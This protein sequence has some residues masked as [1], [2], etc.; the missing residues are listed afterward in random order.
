[1]PV[2]E[3]PEDAVCCSCFRRSAS[4][5]Q[6]YVNA[7]LK[8]PSVS[9]VVPFGDL[10]GTR[11]WKSR[12]P[13]FGAPTSLGSTTPNGAIGLTCLG[14]P[15]EPRNVALMRI[16]T[17]PREL[18]A[19]IIRRMECEESAW[20]PFDRSRTVS[21]WRVMPDPHQ[22]RACMWRV[23]TILHGITPNEVCSMLLDTERW[24]NWR[25]DVTA[26]RN[27][28]RHQGCDVT[29]TCYQGAFL[30]APRETLELSAALCEKELGEL[31]LGWTSCG[32]EDVDNTAAPGH[33]RSFV[34]LAG[35]RL[36]SSPGGTDFT[37]LRQ[38]DLGGRVPAWRA[39]RLGRK[40]CLRL[41]QDLQQAAN[42]S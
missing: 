39:A 10:G 6:T 35:C 31:W 37:F 25:T 28:G 16:P 34:L 15:D 30:L 32:A 11:S 18:L 27:H 36:R 23:Q 40:S 41:C 22:K 26:A 42:R 7:P 13:S 3:L 38:V 19:T 29:S 2:E 9:N 5:P 17:R 14:E 20:T 8:F 33:E 24:I 1:M 12:P 21:H 4:E